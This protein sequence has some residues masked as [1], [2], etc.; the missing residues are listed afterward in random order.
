M[1][2]NLA[3]GK[4]D[5]DDGD[6]S[7][8]DKKADESRDFKGRDYEGGDAILGTPSSEQHRIH[9]YADGDAHDKPVGDPHLSRD[10][11]ESPP[12]RRPGRHGGG[13][14][15]SNRD[16]TADISKNL[17][18]GASGELGNVTDGH[19]SMISRE[20]QYSSTRDKRDDAG[21]RDGQPSDFYGRVDN[22]GEIDSNDGPGAGR[23]GGD[24]STRTEPDRY[25]PNKDKYF[26]DDKFLF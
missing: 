5:D 26:L 12:P 20:A 23:E 16:K 6:V 17:D 2:D 22:R 24:L 14:D 3:R 11:N 10:D 13:G 7:T 18:K 15:Q 25:V 4:R 1:R 21:F 19:V 8:R 9:G